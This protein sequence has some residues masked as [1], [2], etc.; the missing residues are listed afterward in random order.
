MRLQEYITNEPGAFLH[1][2]YLLL[3]R[4]SIRWIDMLL[5]KLPDEMSPFVAGKITNWS[6]SPRGTPWTFSSYQLAPTHHERCIFGGLSTPC[7]LVLFSL[8]W[9]HYDERVQSLNLLPALSPFAQSFSGHC[10]RLSR[11]PVMKLFLWIFRWV[12]RARGW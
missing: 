8:P 3:T 12:E 6:Q 10:W 9:V 5:E 7:H 1:R 2:T 11:I 4:L